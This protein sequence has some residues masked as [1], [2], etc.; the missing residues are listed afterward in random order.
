M[1]ITSDGTESVAEDYVG[2]GFDVAWPRVHAGPNDPEVIGQ[3][4]EPRSIEA[5]DVKKSATII[6]NTPDGRMRLKDYLLKVEGMIAKEVAS[7][8]KDINAIRAKMAKNKAYNAEAR[9]SMKKML[10]AKMAENAKKAKDDL[11]KNMREVQA[12]FAAQAAIANK[13]WK[14]NNKRFKKT[15]EIMKKNKASYA[16]ELK[17]ATLNQQRSLAALDAATNAKIKATNANIA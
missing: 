6:T 7:R 1:Y 5:V 15:R 11:A 2:S 9:A 10:L 4:A 16:K 8:E 13:R 3:V 14:K 12:K 17:M